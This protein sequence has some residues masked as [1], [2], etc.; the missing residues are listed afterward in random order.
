MFLV[1]RLIECPSGFWK[2]WNHC[3]VR[4]PDGSSVRG[5]FPVSGVSLVSFLCSI[6]AWGYQRWVI[7]TLSLLFIG[8]WVLVFMGTR[9]AGIYNLSLNSSLKACASEPSNG[10]ISW[11]RASLL[12]TK[13]SMWFCWGPSLFT[14]R[15]VCV[16]GLLKPERVCY[17]PAAGF[18]LII[19]IFTILGVRK[20]ARNHGFARLLRRQG[21]E[22]FG[23]IL[24]LHTV[25]VVGSS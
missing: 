13:Q 8:Q 7:G 14:V 9:I 18:D 12:T 11:A 20:S 22:Y 24:I 2:H 25:T 6:I 10:I 5:A 19:A 15:N 1:E 17:S 21:I 4:E 23:L 16:D 3:C